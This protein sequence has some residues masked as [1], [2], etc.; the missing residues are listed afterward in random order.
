MARHRSPSGARPVPEHVAPPR[1]TV[2]A[3]HRLPAPPAVPLR[4]RVTVA[5]CAG[6]ALV[7]AGQTALTALAGP[8][9]AADPYEKLAANALLPVADE[10]TAP[11]PADPTRPTTRAVGGDQLSGSSPQALP[12]LDEESE[13][14]V[15]SLTK[16]VDIGERIAATARQIDAALSGG[17]AQAVLERGEA[18]VLPTTGRFTSG[19]GARWGVTH[20]GIDL[21]A[22]IGTPIFAFTDGVVEESGPASGFGMWVVLRHADGTRSVYGHI[23]RSLVSVGQRVSAGEEIAEVGNRGQSTGPHLHFEIWDAAKNKLNPLPIL[24]AMGLKLTGDGA[25][26]PD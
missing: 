17:A 26:S 12:V 2:R 8:A 11:A 22:P 6:G 16:A 9:V 3:G 13:L 19:F 20:Y 1:A 18:Y 14:D 5:A 25:N 7:A 4:V 24:Q 15:A 21:A 23:N 10:I